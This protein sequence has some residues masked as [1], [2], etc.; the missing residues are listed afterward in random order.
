MEEGYPNTSMYAPP[1]ELSA[2][3]NRKRETNEY[4][5]ESGAF[6]RIII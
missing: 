1:D 3:A 5:T 2:E 6:F 4:A